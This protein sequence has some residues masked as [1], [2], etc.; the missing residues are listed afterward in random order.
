MSEQE[1]DVD[2]PSSI[3]ELVERYRVKKSMVEGY[4]TA[5]G[6]GFNEVLEKTWDVL[7]GEN[8]VCLRLNCLTS[9]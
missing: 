6:S 3:K 9:I 8:V 2:L 7:A 5:A 1:N 4:K